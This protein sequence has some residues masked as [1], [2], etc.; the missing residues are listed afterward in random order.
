MEFVGET[1]KKAIRKHANK[2]LKGVRGIIAS[3]ETK[4]Q[5]GLTSVARERLRQS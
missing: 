4:Y 1:V 2:V 5:M 3:V